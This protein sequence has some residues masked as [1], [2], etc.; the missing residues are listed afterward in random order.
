M[1]PYRTFELGELR[2]AISAMLRANGATYGK[3]RVRTVA[4]KTGSLW[5]LAWCA[6]RVYPADVESP[7]P[8]PSVAY[9]TAA[10]IEDWI[11]PA[12][13]NDFLNALSG[14]TVTIGG[15][16]VE[17]RITPTGEVHAREVRATDPRALGRPIYYF[18]LG[19]TLKPKPGFAELVDPKHAYYHD[20]YEAIQWWIRPHQFHGA[21]D[22]RLGS[23]VVE[24]P[25]CR[26]YFKHLEHADS[27]LQIE[28]AAIDAIKPALRMRGVAYRPGGAMQVGADS[29]A[30]SFAIALPH[31]TFRMHLTLLTTDGEELDWHH[32]RPPLDAP[33]RGRVLNPTPGPSLADDEE[34]AARALAAGEGVQVEFKPWV[35]PNHDKFDEIVNTAIA[36]ANT[37]GGVVLLGVDDHC[38]PNSTVDEAIVNATRKKGMTSD[39]ANDW[40]LGVVKQRITGA[41]NRVPPLRTATVSIDNRTVILVEIP[42]GAE[43]PYAR[44]RTHDI[45]VRRGANN[46]R[47]HPDH[48][49]YVLLRNQ[50]AGALSS[51]P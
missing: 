49:L 48:D 8:E 15:F 18:T 33:P 22:G 50:L 25:E 45:Y 43:K 24:L 10:L 14:G 4:T 3:V 41:M 12:A 21:Q 6:L 34:L 44:V 31:D 5:S 11:E 20:L 1:V 35:E 9:E 2:N 27:Q 16:S 7:A 13:I 42:E 30:G 46:V 17:V 51:M 26:A 32:E 39:R 36:F 40:A 23:V 47:P 37:R 38:A 28:V 19:G 29:A